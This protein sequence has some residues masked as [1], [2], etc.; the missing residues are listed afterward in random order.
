MQIGFRDRKSDLY[1]D[2]PTVCITF[3]EHHLTQEPQ[4]RDYDSVADALRALSSIH[5]MPIN[6]FSE[7]N[8]VR[9]ICWALRN[10]GPTGLTEMVLLLVHRSRH[11]LWETA[12]QNLL[13][14]HNFSAALKKARDRL[15]A[16]NNR[17]AVYTRK[18]LDILAYMSDSSIWHA[19]IL[20]DHW[21]AFEY[22]APLDRVWVIPLL[23]GEYARKTF[24]LK[25]V[26]ECIR[27]AWKT[28][29][30][31]EHV[32]LPG[33][34]YRTINLLVLRG[35]PAVSEL[36]E[37]I[38]NALRAVGAEERNMDVYPVDVQLRLAVLKETGGFF[39]DVKTDMPDGWE[40]CVVTKAKVRRRK[41]VARFRRRRS[42]DPS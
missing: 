2:S 16:A 21:D 29:S 5:P 30:Y 15:V 33:L 8:V 14:Q 27:V 36:D 34:V 28:G 22:A 31:L 25:A 37:E 19:Y 13:I 7:G 40:R 12:T 35:Q 4:Y 32:E 10:E 23:E 20:G 38:N 9:G 6:A 42:L 39:K 17:D 3:L 26:V 41:F 18:Y 24:G 11:A 1:Y